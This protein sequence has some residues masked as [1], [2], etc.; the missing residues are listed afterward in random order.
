MNKK[1]IVTGATGLIGTQL[2]HAL[3]SRGD[4]VTAFTRNIESAKKILGDKLLY[5]K[6]DYNNP[7]EWTKHLENK[8]TV[9]HL[10]GANLSG[11]RWT[12]KYKKI[13]LE[14]RELS[15]KNLVSA[16]RSTKNKVKL[17]ISSS[18]VSYYGSRGD[19]VLTED[20][21]P[22]DDFLASVCNVW[23]RE[24][25]NANSFGVRTAMLRQGIVLSKE[26]G[27]LKKFL[28]PFH[29]FIGGSLGN[30]KQWF[31]WI[32]IHDLIA[33]YLFILNNAE[34]SGPVNVVS[35]ENVKMSEFAKTLGR[36]LKRPAIFNVPEFALR[37]LVGEVTSTI[38]SSQR[39]IPKKLIEHG[40][41]FKFD[42]LE[43]A[44]KNLLGNNS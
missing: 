31:P 37:I 7:N 35:P 44:L 27:A 8:D 2:C 20:S 17:F 9:I 10:A 3:I 30:G 13:I 16:I 36:I 26:G 32:H 33:V 5:V 23:E 1:I 4:V 12:E 11:K 6:W 22:G 29:F 14:S 34:I 28:P 38:V 25:E 40:F 41:K 15:T 39:V 43:D 18:G 24:T 19:D 21:K 42:K